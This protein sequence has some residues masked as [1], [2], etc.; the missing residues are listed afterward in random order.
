MGST[1]QE[2]IFDF[3]KLLEFRAH[4]GWLTFEKDLLFEN[5]GEGKDETGK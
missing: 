2:E 1:G 5:F 3:D 4:G